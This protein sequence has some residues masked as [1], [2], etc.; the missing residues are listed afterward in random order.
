MRHL[1]PFL[2]FPEVL[3]VRGYNTLGTGTT[4]VVPARNFYELL[5][6]RATIPGTSG[7]SERHPCPYP[8]LLDFL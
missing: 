1:Y 7:S 6:A 4:C 8:E 3:Y 5:Y 2:E